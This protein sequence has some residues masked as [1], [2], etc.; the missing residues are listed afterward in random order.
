MSTMT[1]DQGGGGG[2]VSSP[3]SFTH[4]QP[5]PGRRRPPRELL[6]LF[7]FDSATRTRKEGGEE[8][9]DE[10]SLRSFAS[11]SLLHASAPHRRWGDS[12]DHPFEDG[13]AR[14]VYERDREGGSAFS[15]SYACSD[16]KSL[17][18]TRGEQGYLPPMG[19]RRR[20]YGSEKKKKKRNQ[21]HAYGG[22]ED[23]RDDDE[24]E[25]EEERGGDESSSA[26]TR[27]A[28]REA[29]A[30]AG[31]EGRRR[32]WWSDIPVLH[33]LFQLVEAATWIGHRNTHLLHKQQLEDLWFGLLALVVEAQQSFPQLTSSCHSRQEASGL[34]KERDIAHEGVVSE[35]ID[36]QRR[37]GDASLHV[38]DVEDKRSLGGEGEDRFKIRGETEAVKARSKEGQER[39]LLR[40]EVGHDDD[41]DKK[42]KERRR[43]R[44]RGGSSGERTLRGLVYELVL[45]ELLSAILHAG[46][47]TISSLPETLKRITQTHRHAQLAV[48]KRPLVSRSSFLDRPSLQQRV[49]CLHG[50]D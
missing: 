49:T 46:V 47:M 21:R 45:S 12:G 28:G 35:E 23:K 5:F 32:I 40:R 6:D 44:T 42:E 31:G 36:L 10:V 19:R 43:E 41:E 2:L 22:G 8:G 29:G 37:D 26:M 20:S 1:G 15:S 11:S 39:D 9:D 48:L 50:A 25:N 18:T 30:V 27:S 17:T 7:L 24:T 3:S 34:R 38:Q 33:S 13:G 4:Q 16:R 14:F